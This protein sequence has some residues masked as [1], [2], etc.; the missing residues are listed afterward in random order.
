M[1]TYHACNITVCLGSVPLAETT[2]SDVVLRKGEVAKR[3]SETAEKKLLHSSYLREKRVL[4]PGDPDGFE[5]NWLGNAPFMQVEAD[6]GFARSPRPNGSPLQDRI[7]QA[8]TL[9]VKLSDKALHSGF[10]GKTHLK[11]EVLFNGQLSA[12]SLIHANDIR[13]GAKSLHQVFSGYRVDFLAERPWVLLPPFTTADGGAR[14]FRRT[15]TPLERFNE[16]S[17]SILKEAKERGT[18][19][20]G[21]SPPSAVFLNALAQMQAPACIMDMQKPGGRKFGVLDVVI[22]AG[23]GNKPITGTSYLKSPQRLKDPDYVAANVSPDGGHTDAGGNTETQNERPTKRRAVS[24]AE[25][26]SACLHP[27]GL[28]SPLSH[29]PDFFSHP[30]SA[31]FAT[32][33]MP[34][35]P[36]FPTCESL[37]PTALFSVTSN[38]RTSASPTKGMA[39]V[40]SNEHC[41]SVLISRVVIS[42][43]SRPVV[44]HR[45]KV[46]HHIIVNHGRPLKGNARDQAES[47]DLECGKL[48]TRSRARQWRG[49]HNKIIQ[50]NYRAT[51]PIEEGNISNGEQGLPKSTPVLAPSSIQTHMHV[52][53]LQSAATQRRAYSRDATPGI[54]GPKAATFLLD[55]PEEVLREAART[56]RSKSPTK[57]AATVYTAPT[58]SAAQIG[59]ECLSGSSPLSSVPG[60]PLPESPI[61]ASSGAFVPPGHIPQLDGLADSA[62]PVDLSHRLAESSAEKASLPTPQLQRSGLAALPSVLAVPKKRK[63]TQQSPTRTPRDPDRLSTVNNPPLND[64]CVIAFAESSK[65]GAEKRILRQVKGER[66]GLFKEEYVVLAVRFFV[67][68]G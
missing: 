14:R 49:P 11:M 57:P 64:D 36:A 22:T 29:I 45:C 10:T 67:A 28:S 9:H 6:D 23:T 38:S 26:P 17:T 55:D 5:L 34:S 46:A 27:G 41:S 13:S 47:P 2:T 24:L 15:I 68:G 39:T 37:P 44:D 19:K 33:T 30:G 66:Q 32:P 12:C 42:F 62:S 1:P 7:A 18:N 50:T 59:K 56:R 48:K 21:D 35:S 54:Q 31:P 65:S 53:S 20:S 4:F 16:I 8:L 58:T 52:P 3:Q 25:D 61:E 40:D 60:S 43:N 51:S 63:L